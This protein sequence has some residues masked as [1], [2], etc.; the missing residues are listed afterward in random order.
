MYGY[1]SPE[2]K[3][4]KNLPNRDEIKIAAIQA[5]EYMEKLILNRHCIFESMGYDKYGRLLGKLYYVDSDIRFYTKPASI[6]DIMI[7]NG[8][9]YPYEG[10]TKKENQLDY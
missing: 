9:G 5:K 8:Y 1:D 2:M 10:G 3:P 4:R 7:D 6:N